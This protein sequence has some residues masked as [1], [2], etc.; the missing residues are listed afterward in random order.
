MKCME[1]LLGDS[2]QDILNMVLFGYNSEGKSSFNNSIEQLNKNI[3]Q[4]GHE[5]TDE[6][7]EKF[8]KRFFKIDSNS[9]KQN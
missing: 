6:F 8:D 7:N 5:M 3:S 1:L 2:I 9:F 4:M